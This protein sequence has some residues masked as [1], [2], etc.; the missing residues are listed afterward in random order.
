METLSLFI[1]TRMLK[2][3][4]LLFPERIRRRVAWILKRERLREGEREGGRERKRGGY[5]DKS[6]G[7]VTVGFLGLLATALSFAPGAKRIKRSRILYDYESPSECT[8]SKSPT[9]AL[10]LIAIVSPVKAQTIINVAT[11]CLCYRRGP[12]QSDYNQ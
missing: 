12:Y 4:K 5:G 9:Q 1:D 7:C 11:S 6:N 2:Q 3:S 10:G 8:H